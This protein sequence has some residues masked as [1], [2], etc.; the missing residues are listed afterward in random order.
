MEIKVVKFGG[1]SLASV[2]Q[3]RKCVEIIRADE[4]RRFIVVSAPGKRSKEDIKITDLLISC[5][6]AASRGESIEPYFAIIRERFL[7][8]AEELQVGND[9]K[10]KLD[11][12]ET[13][14]QK[15]ASYDYTVSRGE[16][17]SARIVAEYL[18]YAFIDAEE[19][20]H[21]NEEGKI[22]SKSYDLIGQILSVEKTAVIP[23]F[24]GRAA[25]GSVKAFSRGGSDI[26]GSIVAKGVKAHVYENWTDVSGLLQ[27][28]PRI[29]ENP[30]PIEEVTYGEL[31]ELAALGANV[32]HEEAIHPVSSAGIPINIRNTNAPEAPGTLI[33]AQKE[34]KGRGITGVSG[35][36]GLSA[37]RFH[38]AHLGENLGLQHRLKEG[39]VDLGWKVLYVS[40][41]CDSLL[42]V[43]EPRENHTPQEQDV[44]ALTEG[45]FLEG[46][47]KLPALCMVGAVGDRL[48]EE[49]GLV[50][51]LA[52]K[53]AEKGIIPLFL[54]QGA[55]ATS[56][57]A[58]VEEEHYQKAIRILAS[59]C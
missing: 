22:S 59:A 54:A 13:R 11:I 12:A 38:L 4:N 23:G 10:E 3:I 17:F 33:V 57:M 55:S 34:S 6:Q 51:S 24:Y 32:F 37:Y 14:I 40:A 53:M 5:Y 27:A 49:G 35:K 8:I 25:D 15:E 28:D 56:F 36:T 30:A 18:G 42:A 31:R 43:L 29:V 39:L 45:L 16:H 48:G 20:I 58:G 46:F 47:S 1:T 26:T 21:F 2:E 7:E 52:I 44:A 41:H 50:A 9:L 19:I